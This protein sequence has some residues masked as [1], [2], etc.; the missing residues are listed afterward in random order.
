MT[1][2]VTIS[3]VGPPV[4]KGR[5]RFSRKAGVAF[6]PTP[7][8]NAEA[9]VRLLA[10]QAMAGRPPLEGPL[11]LRLAAIFEPPR[12]WSKRKTAA[13]LCGLIQPTG[14]PDATNVAKLIEDALNGV[15]YRDDAQIV[16][17]SAS[18]RYGPQPMT[19]V[20]VTPLAVSEAA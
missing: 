18:K 14:R 17:L 2:P 6:T 1:Q 12:S 15:V 5:P 19:V 9:Y 3:V 7:T 8:R 4:G 11:E 16:R 13:A 10:S 20:T